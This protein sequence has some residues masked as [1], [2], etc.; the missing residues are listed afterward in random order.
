MRILAAS[1]FRA[2]SVVWQEQPGQNTLTVVCKATYALAPLVSPLAA[3]PEDV[4][5][6]DN[7]WDDDPQKSLYLPNDLAPFKPRAEVI[8]V[9]AAFAPGAE[10][11]RQVHA[12][13]VVGEL[14]KSIEVFCPRI[15]LPDGAL[16]DG[17]R[18]TQM[19]LRYERAAGGPDTWNPVGINPD[20]VDRYG[21]RTLPNL[22]PPGLAVSKPGDLILPI[23]F[24][25]IAPTWPSRR[26][27][28]RDRARQWSDERW[29]EAPLDEDF[30]GAYFQAAPLDQ[31]VDALR[32]DEKLILENLNHNHPRLVTKLPGVRPRA[33]VEMPDEPVWNLT[34]VA[35]TLWI[36]TQRGL[37]TLTWRGQMPLASREQPGVVRIGIDEPGQPLRWPSSDPPPAI[38]APAPAPAPIMEDPRTMTAEEAQAVMRAV[39]PFQ[40]DSPVFVPNPPR[41]LATADPTG[42]L[43]N[44]VIP[45]AAMPPWLERASSAGAAIAPPPPSFPRTDPPPAPLR[46]PSVAPPPPV[47]PHFRPSEGFPIAPTFGAAPL[48]ARPALIDVPEPPRADARAVHGGVLE[49]SNAAADAAPSP[50]RTAASRGEVTPTSPRIMVELIWHDP[51][52][53]PRVRAV[54]AW[55]PL[56]R[57]A[58]PPP[59]DD[60]AAEK[61]AAESKTHGERTDVI[62][63][64]GRAAATFDVEGAVIDAGADD[65]GLDAPMVMVAGDLELGLDEVKMLE[66]MIGAAGPLSAGDKKV[67]EVIDLAGEVMHTPLGASPAVAAGF[68]IRVREAWLRANRALP[69][70]YLDVHTR[71]L[72]LEQRSYQR[73]ELWNESYIRAVLSPLGEGSGIPTYL[74][75]SLAKQLPLYARFPARVLAEAFPQQDQAESC[76]VALRIAALGRVVTRS[77]R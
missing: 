63:V 71:R 77:R 8:V 22:Q 12:R 23:G 25:P 2:G 38:A 34:L 7:F 59:A 20:L 66:A 65:G 28:L 75:A 74:P 33:R 56:F 32:A 72:L 40:G 42:T 36:D 37:C 24:G 45:R 55:K 53:V 57:E 30:D 54:P 61:R 67:K 29:S 5:E 51:E 58:P 11:V 35:D 50:R 1:P 68:V 19:P 46:P 9:G 10:P 70:D 44:A 18:W 41:S 16:Q 31:R 15:F 4:N 60:P 69:A 14:D 17:P 52:K 47:P 43:H 3:E 73:R 62:A 13:I 49:A 26:E 48:V 76:P 39:L 27:L 6:R 64:L 21:R